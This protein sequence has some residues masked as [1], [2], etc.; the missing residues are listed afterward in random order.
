M[1]Y[2]P[3]LTYIDKNNKEQTK[4]NVDAELVLHS[5]IE[6]P[7][8]DKA[9]IVTG[10]GDY[11]CLIEYLISQNKLKHLAIPNRY[12]YSSLLKGFRKY[13]VYVSDL[14]NKLQK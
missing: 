7:V 11:F 3:T 13:F 1:I 10:D 2:K 8:Y 4:G 12:S 6:F 14:K 5:M 9:I